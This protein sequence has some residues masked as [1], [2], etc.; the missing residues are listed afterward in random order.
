MRS[1][2]GGSGGRS[3]ASAHR[4]QSKKDT[5]VTYRLLQLAEGAYDVEFDGETV[6]SLVATAGGRGNTRWTAELLDERRPRPQPFTGESQGF[7]TFSDALTWFGDPEVISAP[8][9]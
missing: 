1:N 9:S 6:A 2:L 3:E 5:G 4:R 8:A 7:P